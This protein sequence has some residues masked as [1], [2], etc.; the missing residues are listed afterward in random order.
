ML[1][2]TALVCTSKLIV[3][4]ER[5]ACQITFSYLATGLE[6]VNPSYCFLVFPFPNTLVKKTQ[7]S[8]YCYYPIQLK[9]DLFTCLVSLSRSII[10]KFIV[11]SWKKLVK[12]LSDLSPEFCY[13]SPCL[14]F[15]VQLSLSNHPP[16]LLFAF[17]IYY[18]TRFSDR[19]KK[20]IK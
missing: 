1:V 9:F 2:K 16:S 10:T 13:P 17:E 12:T 5:L 15:P 4:S 20:R 19:G 11:A 3:H 7:L 14:N 6:A 18:L 8:C